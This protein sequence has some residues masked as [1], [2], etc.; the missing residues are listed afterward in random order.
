MNETEKSLLYLFVNQF[1][2]FVSYFIYNT[3]TKREDMEMF[4]INLLKDNRGKKDGSNNPD[5][6]ASEGTSEMAIPMETPIV[7]PIAEIA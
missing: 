4:L 5:P 7:E 2:A 6:Q 3:E 1:D